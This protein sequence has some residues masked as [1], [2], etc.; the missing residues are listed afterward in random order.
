MPTPRQ[1]QSGFTLIELLVVIAIIGILS[2]V[3]LASLN[4]ARANA[5]D[6]AIRQTA[7]NIGNTLQL[8]YARDFEY[9]NH[10]YSWINNGSETCASQGFRGE[11]AADLLNSCNAI[12]DNLAYAPGTNMMHWGVRTSDFPYED[13]FSIMIR[14][15]NGDWY[16]VGSSGATYEGPSNP[17]GGTWSGSGCFRNP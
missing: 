15:N 7:Q 2:A 1:L 8:E 3:V 12:I 13:N 6:T 4:D 9:Q 17:G 16:C 11:F 5:R 14:L 10:Q